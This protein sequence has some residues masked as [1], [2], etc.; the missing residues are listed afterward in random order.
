MFLKAEPH[1]TGTKAAP[2]VPLRM[3]LPQG[4][5]VGLVAAQIGFERSV[6]L[7]DRG[8]DQLAAERLRLG[9]H[10]GRDFDDVELGAQAFPRA[11]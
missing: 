10:L 8:L 4:R 9:D 3:Q 2:I 11:T 7:L 1:S 5:L 6:V